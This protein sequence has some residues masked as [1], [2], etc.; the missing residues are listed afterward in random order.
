MSMKKT[1]AEWL[2]D[3]L[4]NKISIVCHDAD[5]VWRL[6]CG[7]TATFDAHHQEAIMD[8]V[9]DCFVNMQVPTPKEYYEKMYRAK[10]TKT[11]HPDWAHLPF[12]G[13]MSAHIVVSI[14]RAFLE[15]G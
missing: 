3:P 2:K 1:K 6:V 15:G 5:R 10:A 4:L 9:A 8:I 11:V 12:D 7:N 14:I 13:R